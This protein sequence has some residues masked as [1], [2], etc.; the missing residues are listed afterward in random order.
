[1]EYCR[2]N[3]VFTTNELKR[4]GIVEPLKFGFTVLVDEKPTYNY[5]TEKAVFT[6][7]IVDSKKVYNVVQLEGDELTEN[8]TKYSKRLV[9]EVDAYM[10]FVIS[11]KK[12]Y[13]TRDSIGKY[14]VVENPFYEECKKISLWISNCY[15]KL[16]A[17]EAEVKEGTRGIPT[18]N[19]VL[20]LLPIPDF[21]EGNVL[22]EYLAEKDSMGIMPIST[23]VG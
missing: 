6:G 10:D 19:E 17:I 16:Y 23:M 8:I 11:N 15:L 3:V 22:G 9:M 2:E 12:G 7:E 5:I 13:E 14:L 4:M 18:V 1:M 21:I 20:N